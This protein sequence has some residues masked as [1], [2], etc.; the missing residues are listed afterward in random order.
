M[1]DFQVIASKMET[2][3]EIIECCYALRRQLRIFSAV[4]IEKTRFFVFA[5][6]RYCKTS[7]KAFTQADIAFE[8]RQF[9][10]NVTKIYVNE[11]KI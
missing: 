1:S 3:S 11:L 8:I 7:K 6:L 2:E 10:K 4:Q 9:Y 5:I